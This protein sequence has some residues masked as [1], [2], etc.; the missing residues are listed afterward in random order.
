[1]QEE[2]EEQQPTPSPTIHWDNNLH[3]EESVD[4]GCLCQPIGGED[5]LQED[6]PS[7]CKEDHTFGQM[8]GPEKLLQE[9]V[10]T[11]KTVM[12]TDRCRDRQ[13]GEI[14]GGA[15]HSLDVSHAFVYDKNV[16]SCPNSR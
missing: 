12:E 11:L 15:Q 8:C 7:L 2:D 1:M 10:D 9:T 4:E 6:N 3:Y 13:E 16:F 5:G 14:P